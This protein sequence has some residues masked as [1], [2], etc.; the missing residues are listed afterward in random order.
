MIL[1]ASRQDLEDLAQRQA[2]KARRELVVEEETRAH[3]WD[4]EVN[5]EVEHVRGD[6]AEQ[7]HPT[8]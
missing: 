3:G 5:G 1:R 6:P 7:H 8:A 4:D 2:L